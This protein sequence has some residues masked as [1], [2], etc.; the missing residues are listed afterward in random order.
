[1]KS[2]FTLAL[3]A[4]VALC[5][6]AEGR[7][8]AI[9]TSVKVNDAKMVAQPTLA[10]KKTAP[11]RVRALQNFEGEYEWV[12]YDHLA[13]RQLTRTVEFTLLDESTGEFKVTNFYGGLSFNAFIDP[14]AGQM[15]VATPQSAG[16]DM[17]GEA[18]DFYLQDSTS[19][20]GPSADEWA[21]G[22]INGAEITFPENQI[23]AF[24]QLP[25]G[26]NYWTLTTGNKF[27][28]EGEIVDD[29]PSEPLEGVEAIAGIY[30]YTLSPLLNGMGSTV[31][32]TIAVSNA[33]TGEVTISGWPQNYVVKGIYDPAAGTLTIANKQNLGTDSYGDTNYF[34]LKEADADGSIV[35][36]ASAEANV[37]GLVDGVNITFP[38]M[39]IW[40][41]GDFN[42]EDLGW[43]WLSYR[44]NF[45]KIVEQGDPNEGWEDFCTAEFEDGWVLTSYNIGGV[46]VMP[47]DMPWTVNVQ[48][49]LEDP[50]LLRLDNPYMAEDCPI[51]AS[52]VKTGG[53]IVFSVAD[54]E[55]VIVYPEIFSGAMNGSNKLYCFNVPGFYVANGYDKDVIVSVIGAEVCGTFDDDTHI[56]SI[57]KSVFNFG[58]LED[59]YYTWQNSAG[60]SLADNMNSKITLSRSM[61][62]IA[63]VEASDDNAPVIYYNLQGVR[64]NNPSNGVF[65]RVQG[66]KVDKIA[67]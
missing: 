16:T 63:N 32:M 54:P 57:P 26:W 13:N 46:P 34:Y 55:F 38:A 22:T 19:S 65:I 45:T 47:A 53:Y 50:N 18:F 7:Q 20:D 14:V 21:I 59:G 39:S 66:N 42:D 62:G 4:A 2:N 28:F 64:V 29:N 5:A 40:A 44:N 3:A 51:P 31:E 6:N 60:E 41:I 8:Q 33:A 36:G 11:A 24:C 37:V 48:R 49:N 58:G 27:T 23:W 25:G 56:V 30:D 1:M 15:K 17:N 67:K 35:D 10:L 9:A 52:N 12:G 61:S 43:W